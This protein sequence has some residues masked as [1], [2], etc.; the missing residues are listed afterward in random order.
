MEPPK[1]E[2]LVLKTYRRIEAN[3]PPAGQPVLKSRYPGNY[4]LFCSKED[5]FHYHAR[6]GAL[7]FWSEDCPVV[8]DVIRCPECGSPAVRPSQDE[9][10]EG[11]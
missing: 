8:L 9:E 4:V 7:P 10:T 11:E 3:F 1:K 6:E 2:K 5:C